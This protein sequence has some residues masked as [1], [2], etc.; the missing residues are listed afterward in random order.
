MK[1]VPEI[2]T[3]PG[4]PKK[5]PFKEMVKIGIRKIYE[6]G[7]LA[8]QWKI[9]IGHLPQCE[10]SKVD[11]VPVD[12]THFS[13]ALYL[14]AFGIQISAVIFIGELAVVYCLD[15]WGSSK[16]SKAFGRTIKKFVR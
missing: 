4:L 1:Y 2:P 9:W 11:V 12:I 5:S 15:L 14:L 16:Y 7:I 6:T 3:G 13:S 10:N 8:H